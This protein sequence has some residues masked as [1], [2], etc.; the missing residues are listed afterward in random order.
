M[1][2]LGTPYIDYAKYYFVENIEPNFQKEN[3]VVFASRMTNPKNPKLYIQTVKYIY[4][5]YY[6]IITKNNW[7][8]LI[9]GGGEIEKEVDA[10]IV[11]LGLSNHLKRC[12]TYDMK[13]IFAKTKIFVSLQDIENFTS[14]SLLEAMSAGNAIICM[15]VG[16]TQRIVQNGINGFLCKEFSV[17]E[18]AHNIIKLMNDENLINNFSYNNIKLSREIFNIKNFA[19]D[20]ESFWINVINKN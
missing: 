16:E 12:I 18:I 13:P 11:S 1:K 6:S 9:Y 4:D 14:L 7:S 10:L 8:F 15:D 3:I 5:N 17:V 19:N 20:I 2:F